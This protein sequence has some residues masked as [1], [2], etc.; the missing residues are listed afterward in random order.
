MLG[1]RRSGVTV[2]LQGLERIGLIAHK[3]GVIT[4]LDREALEVS[5]NGTYVRPTDD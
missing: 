3:R 1:V 4:L 5:S 2:A